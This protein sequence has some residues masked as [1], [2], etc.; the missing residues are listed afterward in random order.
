M[1]HNILTKLAHWRCLCGF[2]SFCL[3]ELYVN[4]NQPVN[5][6]PCRTAQIFNSVKGMGGFLVQNS[7]KS[8]WI[9]ILWYQ[10]K[11]HFI[12][13]LALLPQWYQ[14][15]NMTPLILFLRYKLCQFNFIK[16]NFE[17]ATIVKDNIFDT[18]WKLRCMHFDWSFA[19]PI[20]FMI[21]IT[22]THHYIAW[23]AQLFNSIMSRF[24]ISLQLPRY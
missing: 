21:D 16:H 2:R 9:L 8:L 20:G 5:S 12:N 14:L 24:V 19:L 1:I 10:N 13:I 17:Q 11:Q 22:Y 3:S 7:T 6:T 15:F 4:G 18:H 23:N